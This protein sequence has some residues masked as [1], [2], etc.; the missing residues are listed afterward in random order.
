[1]KTKKNTNF[2][3]PILSL[4]QWKFKCYNLS[5]NFSILSEYYVVKCGLI[6]AGATMINVSLSE[7]LRH[8]FFLGSLVLEIFSHLKKEFSDHRVQYSQYFT[9]HSQSDWRQSF[10]QLMNWNIVLRA[11]YLPVF[12]LNMVN[13]GSGKNLII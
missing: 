9:I 6:M 7:D 13:E 12:L 3:C 5:L 4:Q 2:I 10:V 1:M 11:V 8:N